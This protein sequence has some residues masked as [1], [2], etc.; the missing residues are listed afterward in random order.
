MPTFRPDYVCPHCGRHDQLVVVV[1]VF[2]QLLQTEDNIETDTADDNDEH[3]DDT[4]EMFCNNERCQYAG[5]AADFAPFDPKSFVETHWD[6]EDLGLL[7]EVA[8][9]LRTVQLWRLLDEVDSYKNL[10]GV[11]QAA[12]DSLCLSLRDLMTDSARLE[13][14]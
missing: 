13:R 5:R 7:V 6:V 10:S 9:S 3:W 4:S 1:Q 2:R 12:V 14:E 8:R 11:D